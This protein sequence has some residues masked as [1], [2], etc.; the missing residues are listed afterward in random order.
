MQ[1]RGRN[2]RPPPRPQLNS[3]P[4]GGHLAAI[5][6][7]YK[8]SSMTVPHSDRKPQNNNNCFTSALHVFVSRFVRLDFDLA[9]WPE[10]SLRGL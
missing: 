4:H 7:K 3:Q 8:P 5:V 6:P 9:T 1:K 2:N 10:R